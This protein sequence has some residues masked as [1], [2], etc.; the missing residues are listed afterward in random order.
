MTRICFVTAVLLLTLTW[1][2]A[3]TSISGQWET[4]INLDPSGL[5][6]EGSL[7][8]ISS[9]L[10]V[11]YK[12]DSWVLGSD[13]V[14]NLGGFD[15]QKFTASGKLGA[16]TIDSTLQLDP[17]VVNS[18]TY[19]LANG[20]SY[21]NQAQSVAGVSSTGAQAMWSDP[22]W[23]CV[24]LDETITY[25]PSAFSSLQ[26]N[27]QLSLPEMNLEWLFYLKGNDF[28]AKT[29]TGKWVYGNPYDHWENVITQTGSYTAS[30][31]VPRYGAG[32]KLTLSGTAGDI[33]ITS[34]TYFNLEEYSYNELK[35]LAYAKTHIRDTLKLGGSY[36]LPKVSGETWEATFTREFITLEGMSL[37]CA[38]FDVGLNMTHE[39]FDWFKILVTD[40]ELFPFLYLDTLITFTTTSQEIVLEPALCLGDTGS[41]T[42]HLDLDWNAAD[43]SLN[44]LIFN[45]ISMS[46]NWSGLTFSSATSFNPV[47][48]PSGYYLAADVNSP[49]TYGF[50]V[51]DK[52]FAKEEFSCTTGVGYYAEVC[53]PEEYYNIWE[54]LTIESST[55]GCRDED[56][57]WEVNTYFGDR[58]ILIADSFWF[59]YKDEDGESYKYNTED[60]PAK[61]TAPIVSGSAKPYCEDDNVSY[62]VAYYDADENTML[63]WVKTDVDLVIPLSPGV[64]LA[65]GAAV[66][67]Y[68]WEELKLGFV[69][70]W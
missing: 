60:T 31:C 15:L 58:Q 45:G 40:I 28:E 24:Q 30:A 44:G 38:Q 10:A 67:V 26:A 39:G 17:M 16:L 52:N 70:G 19:E 54:M 8:D 4:M 2:V 47:L 6:F 34:H 20:E 36:Y 21:Q 42:L 64:Q 66:S 48:A 41:V 59:W 23:N 51:P 25:A 69:L 32:S 5:A 53:Y 13:S 35:T 11:D 7:E 50:F 37:G 63:G 18:V 65:F 27:A 12:H 3:A 57:K 1:G 55:E 68:G 46:C 62:G 29:V 9:T 43:A 33:L 56:C 61:V 14:F 49:T 22:I